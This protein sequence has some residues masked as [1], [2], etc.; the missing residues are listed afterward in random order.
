V[1]AWM[2]FRLLLAKTRSVTT[3]GAA[4][5]T[6][7][8]LSQVCNRKLRQVCNRKLRQ[9]CNRKLRQACNRKLRQACNRKLR[10]ACNR[11]LRQVCNRRQRNFFQA[12]SRPRTG[13]APA[14]PLFFYFKTPSR[15]Q[16][17]K[18]N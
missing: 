17:E 9:V 13:A 12:S 4:V 3:S 16:N 18:R 6:C 14:V 10:Q 15:S 1:L 2:V 5:L 7:R 8:A 11:K